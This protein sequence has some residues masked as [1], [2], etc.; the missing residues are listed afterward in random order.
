MN[1]GHQKA[2]HILWQLFL[3]GLGMDAPSNACYIADLYYCI[4]T[5]YRG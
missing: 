3:L 2:E 5:K 4:Q 1:G